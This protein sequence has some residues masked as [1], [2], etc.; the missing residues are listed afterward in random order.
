M[1]LGAD[2]KSGELPGDKVSEMRVL[3]GVRRFEMPWRSVERSQ[4][5]T[6]ILHSLLAGTCENSAELHTLYGIYA[7]YGFEGAT[8]EPSPARFLMR[9]WRRRSVIAAI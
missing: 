4:R 3:M 9:I 8:F 1:W 7:G 5:A 2:I 6:S